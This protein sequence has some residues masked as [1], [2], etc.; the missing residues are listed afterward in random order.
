MAHQLIVFGLFP[1]LSKPLGV[2]SCQQIEELS[3]LYRNVYVTQSSE[4][5][6]PKLIALNIILTGH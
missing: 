6:C 2:E 1:L 4:E 5:G 3:L